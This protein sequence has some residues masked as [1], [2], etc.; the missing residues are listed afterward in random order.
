MTTINKSNRKPKL[1]KPE[2]NER[3]FLLSVPYTHRMNVSKYGAK[4][5]PTL[6]A[7]CYIGE[8]LPKELIPYR[9]PLYSYERFKENELNNV[10]KGPSIPE[11]NIILRDH[12][13]EAVKS[14]TQAH[15]I[16]RKGFLL[17][18]DVGLGKTISTW[19]AISSIK[20]IQ[21][22]LIVSPLAVTAGWRNTIK[23]MGNNGKTVIIINYERLQNL[24][25]LK[26]EKTKTGKR[27]K[28]K[29]KANEGKAPSFDAI[30]WDES[31]RLKNITSARSKFAMK[32]NAKC[33]FTMW[34]SA[35]AGQNPLELSYLSPLL[36]QMTGY[37]VTDLQEFEKWCNSMK[38]GVSRVQYGAW[39]WEGKPEDT[40]RVNKLLFGGAIPAG[41]RRK[42]QD[43]DGWPEINRMPTPIEF[44]PEEQILYE[45]AWQEFRKELGLEKTN[46][47]SNPQN[48]LAAQLRFRQKT[49]ILRIS[50]TIALAKELLDKGHQVAISVA[51]QETLEMMKE[52]FKKLKIDVAE[53][54][55]RQNEFEKEDN[56]LIF[57][58]GERKVVLFTVEEGIS[59]HQ[60]EYNNITRSEIIHDIRWSAI[61][62]TQIEGRC[63]R[64]GQFAQIYWMIAPTTIDERIIEIVINK[65]KTM[66][67]M[68]DDDIKMIEKI[69][70]ELTKL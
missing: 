26:E 38:L 46:A 56:R 64:D 47:K 27:K 57:Q 19:K 54:H 18:D 59:L 4:W 48:K 12:Q 55:G 3:Y 43:I 49:S 28:L 23:W 22:V 42:P 53:I 33:K 62:M 45:S 14:I 17:A 10:K 7:F 8:V 34:L 31:H 50:G 5:Q 11:K 25:E 69:E 35:T 21:T 68:I 30:I 20:E 60:G 44:D 29:T 24:F 67:A 41:L 9:P 37:K 58:K 6:K 70:D 2:A 13:V 51:F 1:Q 32:L 39:I 61:Q 40:K 52:E 16:K 15:R 66:N 65:M 63:H 36:A